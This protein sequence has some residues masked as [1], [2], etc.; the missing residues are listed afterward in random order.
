MAIEAKHSFLKQVEMRLATEITADAMSK[1][2]SIISDVMEGFD[3]RQT[4]ITE[5]QED[6]LD[7]YIDAM[8]IQGRSPKT[9]QRYQLII[10]KMMQSVKVSTR[11]ITVHHIRS[12]LT[13]EKERGIMDSTL[14]SERQVLSAYFNWLQRESLIERNPMANVGAIK[15]A[16][17]KKQVLTD[18]DFEKLY[19]NCESER[20]RAIIHF[21]AATGCRVSEMCELD[22]DQIDFEKLKGVVHGKG[23]KERTIYF[24]SVTAVCL[25]TYLESRKDLNPA[26]FIGKRNERLMQNGVR[27][28]LKVLA[29]KAGVEHVHPHKFRRTRATLMSKHGMSLQEIA[30]ILG[31][32]KIDTTM[33]YVVMDEEEIDHS[34]RRYA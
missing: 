34:Y 7:C 6:L 9:I 16:K 1:T 32:E 27:Q 23:D 12:Y 8:K 11:M 22:R 28:M 5:A 2:L 17:R 29:A 31:H 24:D 19:R 4:A 20:D 3:V 14:E 30:A 15:C 18:V 10:R 25:R 21:L 13:K 26:L 33:R